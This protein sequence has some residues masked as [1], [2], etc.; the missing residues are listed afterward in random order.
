MANPETL[1]ILARLLQDPSGVSFS[2]PFYRE[3][4]QQG[5]IAALEDLANETTADSTPVTLQDEHPS[6]FDLLYQAAGYHPEAVIREQAFHALVRLAQEGRQPAVDSIYRLSVEEDLLAARQILLTHS[7]Q[8]SRP[9]LRALFDWFTHLAAS[10]NFPQDRLEWITRA[11][12][13]EASQALRRRLLLTA[14]QVGMVNWA[15]IASALEDTKNLSGLVGSYPVFTAEERQ[16]M[17]ALLE[18]QAQQGSQ[19]AVETLCQL[20]IFHQDP[21]ARQVAQSHHYAPQD[22]EQRAL[23]YFLIEDWKA[24]DTLDFN[25]NLIVNAYES[26]NRSLRRRLLEHS[27]YTGRIDWLRGHGSP[28][29]IRWIGDL[30]DADWELSIRR[31]NQG[32][33]Y[34]DLWRLAQAAPP[35]W[36]AV[37]LDLLEKRGWAPETEEDRSEYGGLVLLARQS[38][39]NPLPVHPRKTLHAPVDSLNCLAIHPEGTALAAG[40]NDQRVYLWDLPQGDLRVPP[41]IGPTPTVRALAFCPESDLLACASSDHRI[42]VFLLPGGQVIKT[43]EGHQ[44]MIR[45]LTFHSDGRVLYSAGFDGSIRFWRFP[46]GPELKILNPRKDE[47][48]SIAVSADGKYLLSGGADS[49]VRVWT[50][51]EGASARELPGHLDT[52][53]HLASSPTG[54]LAASAGRDGMIRLWNFTSGNLLRAIENPFGALTALALHPG[55]QALIGGHSDGKITLWSLSTGRM[56]DRLSGH[57]HPVIGLVLP[58]SGDALYSGDASGKIQAWDLRTFLAVR[59]ATETA[60]PGAAADL[61]MRL[62][63]PGLQAAERTWLE[64]AAALAR[65]RQRYDIELSDAGMVSIGEFDI[66]IS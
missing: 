45:S 25:R 41:L 59:L 38:L 40:G 3:L 53:T 42:R 1:T 17:L 56:I 62:K 66:E 46:F 37:I 12:L 19:P 21:K 28:G 20:F 50:L 16:L 15:R 7:W 23:F 29:E 57:E 44:A 33:K 11:Y 61:Q 48:F 24:Y 36:S 51:P 26:A 58:L 22:P 34:A 60:R 65:L 18:E 55:E 2:E 32:E 10:E 52:I 13:D 27:R 30:A 63:Q 43:L 5:V 9:A 31:L 6:A 47:I 54:D 14:P 8:P 35:V 39:A 49:M 4:L 64:F